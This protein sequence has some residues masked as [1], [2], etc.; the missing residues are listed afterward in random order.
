ME[1]AATV[2]MDVDAMEGEGRWKDGQEGSSDMARTQSMGQTVKRQD[3]AEHAPGPAIDMEDL[4]LSMVGS[5]LQF[6]SVKQDWTLTS[7]A[8]EAADADSDEQPAEM[9]RAVSQL[10]ALPRAS[11]F[12]SSQSVSVQDDEAP[13]PPSSL[14]LPEGSP[15]RPPPRRQFDRPGNAV[16]LIRLASPRHQQ[17]VGLLRGQA[18]QHIDPARG[19][20]PGAPMASY[21]SSFADWERESK[22]RKASRMTPSPRRRTP[23]DDVPETLQKS[24]F[25]L[26]FAAGTES[27]PRHGPHPLLAA[28][29]AMQ[30]DEHAPRNRDL[31]QAVLAQRLDNL[32][33]GEKRGGPWTKQPQEAASAS[34]NKVLAGEEGG[35]RK[36]HQG[37]HH[38]RPRT[39][40]FS[41]SHHPAP[42]SAE[43]EQIIR[44]LDPTSSGSIPPDSFVPL[45]FWLGLTRRRGA[46][47]ATLELAFGT[48]AIAV[49]SIRR[50]SAYA[51]VQLRLVDGLKRL[52]RRESL[53]QPCEFI[54]SWSRLREWF[55]SMKR[56]TTS[57]VEIVEVQ[58][59]FARMD[60]T[61]DRA[62]LFRFVSNFARDSASAALPI[63]P[64]AA[65][66]KADVFRTRTLGI[67]EFAAMLCRCLMTWC[68]L[69]AMAIVN[70]PDPSG[71]GFGGNRAAEPISEQAMWSKAEAA[72]LSP[73]GRDREVNLRWTQLQRRIVVSLLVNHRFWGRESRNVLAAQKLQAT[74]ASSKELSQEEWGLLF[75]RVRAQG[76]ASTLADASLFEED[77]ASPSAAR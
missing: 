73:H 42:R 51:E 45:M 25:K 18:S 36:P 58:N 4:E 59:L 43:V 46:A 44:L 63:G 41:P 17:L 56:D 1:S 35:K 6:V 75:Q 11:A 61:D 52:A 72:A 20:G 66:V 10:P 33:W 60:V 34:H 64:S 16:T 5:L 3:A 48:G 70:A 69:R 68:L 23:L 12:S 40:N 8:L 57:R 27:R 28:I 24:N 38:A 67:Q 7:A 77:A 50:L 15:P 65:M 54:T 53:E 37:M 31:E 2:A 71:V 22:Q 21:S 39:D 32:R 62:A 76:I 14:P 19:G 47:L 49:S 9:S 55:Y 29:E 13:P 74:S 26:A 30:D